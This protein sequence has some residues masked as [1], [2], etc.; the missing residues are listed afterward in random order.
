M[1][2]ISR[3]KNPL[4]EV[5]PAVLLTSRKKSLP[6]V[7][8]PAAPAT[9]KLFYPYENSSRREE[10]CREHLKCYSETSDFYIF[11]KRSEVIG[12]ET[13]FFFSMAYYR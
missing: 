1:L 7:V 2:L 10:T 8:L 3:R 9:S 11:I 13:I 5:L 12:D 4:P 6:L